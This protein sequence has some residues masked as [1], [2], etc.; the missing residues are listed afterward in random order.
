M[1]YVPHRMCCVCRKK[2]PQSELIR[3]THSPEGFIIDKDKKSDGRGA[4]VCKSH[5][6]ISVCVKKRMFNKSFRTAV[7]EELYDELGKLS[8]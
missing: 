1:K 4:Y 3:V 2:L 6:C 8:E 5:D 7:P